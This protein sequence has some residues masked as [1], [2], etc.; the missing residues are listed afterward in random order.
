ML[1]GGLL[2]ASIAHWPNAHGSDS[3][4]CGSRIV[5]VEDRAAKV[6]A[7]CGEPDFRDVFYAS[8][9]QGLSTVAEVEHWTY[10]PGPNQL[11]R[12][13]KMRNGRLADIETG[14][15]GFRPSS[16]GRCAPSTMNEG[17][18]KYRLLARCGEPLTRQ[19]QGFVRTLSQ[20]PGRS[21]FGHR[22]AV[23]PVEVY[24]EEWVYNFGRQHR[25]R[26]LVLENGKVARVESGDRGFN[27]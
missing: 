10:N 16:P 15:Y 22:R 4:R 13:L 25:M 11:I 1:C 6:L 2:L 7:V 9:P 20:Y 17:I 12:V 14:G 8:H 24:R 23:R 26:I 21:A 27:P 3:W 5:S 19:V 18:S